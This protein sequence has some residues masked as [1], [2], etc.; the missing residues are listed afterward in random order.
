MGTVFDL[1]R[2]RA[3]ADPGGEPAI[4]V[5]RKSAREAVFLPLQRIEGLLSQ[6][7]RND[8]NTASL[9]EQLAHL[10]PRI[11]ALNACCPPARNH[12]ESTVMLTRAQFDDK[13]A[14]V[15]SL[16]DLESTVRRAN[17]KIEQIGAV[18]RAADDLRG[19]KP[20]QL[21]MPDWE[22][23]D[24]TAWD[25][26]D[27]AANPQFWLEH[28][29]GLLQKAVSAVERGEHGE[30]DYHLGEAGKIPAYINAATNAVDAGALLEIEA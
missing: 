12:S 30:A 24:P 13:D 8:F 28:C 26:I 7:D 10:Q 6:L 21:C 15:E 16:D 5:Q 2:P 22:D 18:R 9:R 29:Y 11:D 17:V 25:A 27:Y 1:Y 19:V 3:G 14:L 4:Q 23:G 20:R